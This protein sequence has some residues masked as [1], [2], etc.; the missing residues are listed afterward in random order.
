[1]TY[2]PEDPLE[3]GRSCLG[4]ALCLPWS[5]AVFITLCYCSVWPLLGGMLARPSLEL[6]FNLFILIFPP[7]ESFFWL[8]L[9][10]YSYI[11]GM[12]SFT[13]LLE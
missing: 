11:D 1:M 5:L 9:I 3:S 8:L 10:Y 12:V 6:I 2:Q 7:T 4:T 13:L